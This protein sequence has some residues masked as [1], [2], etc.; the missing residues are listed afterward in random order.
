MHQ[1]PL[2]LQD[3]FISRRRSI[4]SVSL[5]RKARHIAK[6]QRHKTKLPNKLWESRRDATGACSVCL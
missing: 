4:G 6:L 2:K 1:D 5:T 3:V